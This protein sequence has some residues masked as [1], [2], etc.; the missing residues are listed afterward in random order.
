MNNIPFPISSSFLLAAGVLLCAI[1][2]PTV[3]A[4]LP[5][6]EGF[7]ALEAGDEERAYELLLPLAEQGDPIAEFGLGLLFDSEEGRFEPSQAANWYRRAG[8]NGLP[9]GTLFY[10]V[11][12]QE[13]NGVPADPARAAE[14]YER[15]IRMPDLNGS[16]AI[17]AN[18]LGV[19]YYSGIG[20]EQDYNEA[21]RLFTESAGV[22]YS[23]AAFR[24]GYMRSQG[25]GVVKS[26]ST[27][28]VWLRQ[29]SEGGHTRAM[30]MLM[31][32]LMSIGGDDNLVE[33]YAWGSLAADYD[34]VQQAT[35]GRFVVRDRLTPE[36]LAA[37]ERLREEWRQRL[38]SGQ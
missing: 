34:P 4:Q 6:D 13:G 15:V 20:V 25:E 12:L 8:E 18:S 19:L 9:T 23:E 7:A 29:A 31:A 14:L 21:L 3:F 11:F 16:Q 2:S 27:A 33:A 28:A 22:G 37:A 32:V 36:Q 1:A 10:A 38:T 26:D 24:I 17:A 5:S 35:A 30:G